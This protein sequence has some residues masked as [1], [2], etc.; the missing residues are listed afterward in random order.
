MKRTVARIAQV[1]ALLSFAA[2]A[3]AEPAN[4]KVEAVVKAAVNDP[5]S[6]VFDSGYIVADAQGNRVACGSIRYRNAFGGIVRA[7]YVIDPAFAEMPLFIGPTPLAWI[8]RR[9]CNKPS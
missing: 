9:L 2:A 5:D 4:A 7:N 3:C 8:G 6:V 1:I